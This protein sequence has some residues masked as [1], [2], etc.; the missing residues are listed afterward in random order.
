MTVDADEQSEAS[1]FAFVS[2]PGLRVIGC[3]HRHAAT[4]ADGERMVSQFGQFIVISSSLRTPV[5]AKA[6]P[7]KLFRHSMIFSCTRAKKS[8]VSH[9][10]IH[11]GGLGVLAVNTQGPRE[12]DT[13]EIALEPRHTSSQKATGD[14]LK[15]TPPG[16]M[17]PATG[18]FYGCIAFTWMNSLGL[19]SNEGGMVTVISSTGLAPLDVSTG[20][21][22]NESQSLFKVMEDS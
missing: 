17:D 22:T 19:P 6:T 16:R 15:G 14:A 5:F 18:D 1:S 9:G 21:E 11:L 10:Q 20:V 12:D 7:G 13:L 4:D 3:G 2:R 8:K